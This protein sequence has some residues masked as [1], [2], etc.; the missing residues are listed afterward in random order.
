MSA[1]A[2]SFAVVGGGVSG[3]AAAFAL[4][5]A[6]HEVE[7][8]EC[9]AGLG[10][11]CAPGLLGDRPVMFGGKN[12]GHRYARFRAFT[13]ALGDH[14]YEPFGINSSRV[15]DGR[16]MTIDSSR[17][18]RS[19][20]TALQLGS[21]RA[22][23]RLVYLAARIRRSESNRYLGLPYFT[24]LGRRHDDAP[25]A[26]HFDPRTT[27]ALLRPMT[28]R[29]NGAEPD[30]VFLG[31]FG[32]NLGMLLDSFDQLCFGIQPVLRDFAARVPV[33]LGTRAESIV[34]EDGAVSGL[35]LANADGSHETGAYDGVVIA[36][37]ALAA[38][39]LLQPHWPRLAE[40]LLSV[41]YCPGAVILTEYDRP[42]LTAAVRALVFG[43]GACSNAGA[44]G[45]E[46]RHIVRYT[47]SGR[48]A[49]RMLETGASDEELLA[50]GEG[51]LAAH[52][53][54][55]GAQ[56]R[57]VASRRWTAAYCAYTP[58]HGDFLD[59]VLGAVRDVPGLQLAGDYMRGASI[60]ACFRSGEE[61]AQRLSAAPGAPTPRGRWRS[62]AC[63]PPQATNG[64]PDGIRTHRRATR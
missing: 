41:R 47:F 9:D 21:P 37:P 20:R 22:L 16:V 48:D 46:D 12:I 52:A 18:G 56:R 8:I 1:E 59:A 30:E 55:P 50:V 29:M 33:R 15:E 40:R 26:A 27:R 4:H 6:G 34:V 49:R 32:T 54:L 28:V 45:I 61:A 5:R 53:P 51:Q 64:G 36:V 42:V 60:E 39:G 24:R 25:L 44:Y 19:L 17:R 62:A 7:L 38:A 13:A 63:A 11:R 3:L 31:T 43:E 10:G 58:Y 23:V 57:H 35:R 14:P 2:A